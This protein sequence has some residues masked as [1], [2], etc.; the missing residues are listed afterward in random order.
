[1]ITQNEIEFIPGETGTD[2]AA[3]TPGGTNLQSMVDW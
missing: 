1:M 2:L 3:T